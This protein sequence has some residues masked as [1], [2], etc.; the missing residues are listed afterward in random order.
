MPSERIIFLLA[1]RE[2]GLCN[3]TELQELDEWYASFSRLEHEVARNLEQK[4]KTDLI[5][6]SIYEKIRSQLKLHTDDLTEPLVVT[7]DRRRWMRALA[8]CASLLLL[9]AVLFYSVQRFNKGESITVGTDQNE[10]TKLVLPDGSIVRLKPGS[11]IRYDGNMATATT[12]ELVLEGEGFFEIAH[13]KTHPFVVHVGEL[14]IRVLGTVFNIKS[15]ISTPTIETTLF[16]GSVRIEKDNGTTQL[17]TLTPNQR[18]I[19]SAESQKLSVNSLPEFRK[20]PSGTNASATPNAS[21][22]TFDERPIEEL[23]SHLEGKFGVNIY[24]HNRSKL[25]CP[26]TAD[27]EKETLEEILNLLKINYGID[28]ALYGTELFIEGNICNN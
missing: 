13:D 11:R 14:D 4:F 15:D 3:A 5:E 10:P 21:S 26:I 6:K 22:M 2:K 7:L 24:I 8:A 18:A 1:K 16:K 17:V 25:T 9:A 12:R 28:Y 20:I 19:Y 27:L 23:L